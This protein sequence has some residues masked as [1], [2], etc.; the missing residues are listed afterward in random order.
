MSYKILIPSYKRAHSQPTIELLKQAFSR[1][2]IIVSTQTKEDY[3]KYFSRWGDV[4]TVIFR[5]GSCVGDN[6][7]TLLQWCEENGVGK[8]LMLDDDISGFRMYTRQTIKDAHLIRKMFDTCFLF[9]EKCNAV[10]WGTYPSNCAPSMSK[11]VVNNILTGTCFGILDTSLRF[12]PQ[13]RIK[14]DYELCLRMMAKRKNVI[15][16]N[17][18]A[19]NALHKTAGGCMDDWE[20]VARYTK[21]SQMLCMAYPDFIEPHPNKRGEVRFKKIKK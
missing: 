12:D 21:Y 8:A 14:E 4:A 13:F 9:A 15:R 10:L 19:P 18:F 17:S 11:T 3:E 1:D 7:N 5:E 2:E 20:D 6:R 16:F